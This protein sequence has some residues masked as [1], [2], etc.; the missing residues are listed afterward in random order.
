LQNFSMAKA[1]KAK[2]APVRG[3]YKQSPEDLEK[4]GTL[5]MKLRQWRKY[6]NSMTIEQLAAEARVSTGT[7]SGLEAADSGFSPT[8]IAK[9]CK[10]LDITTAQ[11]FG[12]NPLKH[13]DFWSIWDRADER[14]RE[15]IQD[16]AIGVVGKIRP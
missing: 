5:G 4:L 14:Q 3:P 16:H 15:R 13:P 10:A 8:T 1:H 11:L 7:I 2:I 12:T 6:R 9:L